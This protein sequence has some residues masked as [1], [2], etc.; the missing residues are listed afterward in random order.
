MGSYTP[1]QVL[2]GLLGAWTAQQNLNGGIGGPSSGLVVYAEGKPAAT[3][4]LLTGSGSDGF[5]V[6]APNGPLT[7]SSPNGTGSTIQPW[8]MGLTAGSVT[9]GDTPASSTTTI[10]SGAVKQNTT[11]RYVFLYV[12]VTYSPTTTAAA[13]AAF[14]LGASSTPAAIFTNSEP[15]GI[16][17]GR[18]DTL[19]LSIPPG[20]YYSV[21]VTNAT[22]GTPTEVQ[23]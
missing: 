5:Y 10:T 19:T 20:W 11:G 12:P 1:P 8:V 4:L 18:V 22:I 14:A 2:Y 23:Q 7:L 15:A 9:V 3:Q 21:T 6:E 17:A 16:A 13:T